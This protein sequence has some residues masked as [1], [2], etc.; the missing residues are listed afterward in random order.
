MALRWWQRLEIRVLLLAT[1]L[2]L[3]GVVTVSF[4]VFHLMRQGLYEGARRQSESTADLITRS[5]E[6]VM[7]DGRAEITRTLVADLR[8]NSGIAGLDV[9]NA[10]GREAFVKAGASPDREAVERL[11]ADPAPYSVIVGDN[12]VF[13]RPLLNGPDCLP[14]HDSDPP[15]L[16]ATK[17]S[18]PLQ[19]TIGGGAS[20]IAAALFWSLAGVLVMGLMFWWLIRWLVVRPVKRM[21]EATRALAQGDLTIDIPAPPSGDLGQLW[22]SLRDSV[23]SLGAVILRIHE[24][25]RRVAEAAA[26][27]EQESAAMVEATSSEAD[28]HASIAS[29]MEQMVASVGQIAEDIEGLSAAAETLRATAQEMSVNT[30]EVHQRSEELT[31][32]VAEVSSTAGEMSHTIRELTWGTEHLSGVSS[33]TLAAVRDVEE[34]LRAVEAGADESAASSARVRQEAEELGLRAVNRTLEG[35]ESIRR[36]VDLGAAA[37]QALGQRSAKIGEILDVINEVND[38]T[39]LLSLNAAILAAQAGEHGRGFQVVAAEIRSLAVRTANSTVE[40]AE[41]I[42]TVRTEVGRAVEAMSVGRGEVE[43]GFGYAREAGAALAKIVESSSTSLEKASAIREAAHAQSLGLSRMRESMD[44]LEK[45]A[46]FLAQGTGEQKREADR[47]HTAMEQLS[48]SSRQISLANGEQA[49]AGRHA[50]AAAERVSNGIGH[51]AL[52]LQEQRGGCRQIRDAL[53][54]IVDLPRTNRALLQRINLGL[55]G[56]NADTQLLETEVSR[57]KVIPEE[58]RGALRL[59]VV[60]LESPARMHGRFTPLAAYLGRALGRPVELR[61]ALDFSA[62]VEDLGEGRTQFAY[63]TPS[64][65]V[66]ARARFGATLLATALRR[67]KPFQHAVIVCRRDAAL[68]TLADLRG[69]SFAFGD[70]N[71]TS[72]HIVPRAMLLE[73]GVP[74]ELLGS[75]EHLGHHDAVATAVLHGEFDAGAVMESVAARYAAEGLIALAQSPPIPEFNICASRDLEDELRARLGAALLALSRK[76]TDGAAVL[77]ALY[78]DYTGFVQT[79]DADYD[80]IRSMMQRLKLTE[81]ER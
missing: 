5:V 81:G 78:P 16:G 55:R 65:Y 19:E 70:V 32:T 21:S 51:M 50:L 72:S 10:E 12:L 9:L 73:A 54:P 59:G 27:T 48:A 26:K 33:E 17:V 7:K 45:M 30:D 56:I 49:A 67:G 15:L 71:S 58:S 80:G 75:Y 74:V 68:R 4:G 8:G 66:L 69:R 46:Q 25:S 79:A 18:M 63:L 13:F 3:I 1:L 43:A 29:S 2:P 41:L 23:R 57:F 24:V 36:A 28:S 31:V 39:G 38:R 22:L 61:V 6:R 52:T 34:S 53:V 44:L 64:T 37:V 47:I 42:H 14:C 76:S 35:M 60:P 77:D 62:A 40:I 11:R 20:L